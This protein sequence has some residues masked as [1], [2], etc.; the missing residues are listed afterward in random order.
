VL[1]RP[2]QQCCGETILLHSSHSVALFE[3]VE[4]CLS[5]VTK[6]CF[7]RQCWHRLRPLIWLQAF[8]CFSNALS[9]DPRNP[10]T[11]VA[12]AALYKSCGLLPEATRSLE[13]ALEERHDDAVIRQALAVVLT[14]LGA[15]VHCYA[16]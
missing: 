6:P 12:A 5:S 15:C 7:C 1:Q 11:L 8:A 9:M 2:R 13:L 16:S 10:D 3:N 4:C 14:D